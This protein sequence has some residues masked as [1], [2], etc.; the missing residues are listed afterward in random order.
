MDFKAAGTS[1][2]ITALQMDIK[3]RGISK[4]VLAESFS[5]SEKALK[6]FRKSIKCD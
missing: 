1:K 5:A 6:K 4:E 2:G 3:V